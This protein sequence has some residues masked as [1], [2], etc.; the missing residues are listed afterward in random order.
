MIHRDHP[1]A[2]GPAGRRGV[3]VTV[4][5]AAD[6]PVT[7]RTDTVTDSEPVDSDSMTR[8]HPDGRVT[9]GRPPAGRVTV[10]VP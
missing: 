6:L 4:T 10:T 5:A 7:R 9:V 2:P 3:T 8:N 1:P